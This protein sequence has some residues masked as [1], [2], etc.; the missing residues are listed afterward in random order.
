MREARAVQ[1]SDRF[2]REHRIIL[3]NITEI[4]CCPWVT[5][6]LEKQGLESEQGHWWSRSSGQRSTLTKRPQV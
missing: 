6:S 2:K 5:C 3:C 1:Q 4:G